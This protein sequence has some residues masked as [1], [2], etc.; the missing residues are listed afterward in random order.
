MDTDS[1]VT[2]IE[3]VNHELSRKLKAMSTRRYATFT[4]SLRVSGKSDGAI[5]M[6]AKLQCRSIKVG[7]EKTKVRFLPPPVAISAQRLRKSAL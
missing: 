5:A 6:D 2:A 1:R 3:Q 7:E 4:P